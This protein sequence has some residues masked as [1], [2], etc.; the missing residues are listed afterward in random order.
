MSALPPKSP[1]PQ[2]EEEIQDW[3]INRL[4]TWLLLNPDEIDIEQPFA[5]YGLTS[6][7]AV[8]M[9]ADLEDWLGIELSPT[10]AYEYPTIAALSHHLTTEY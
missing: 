2:R 4:S 8:S 1:D 9:T 6:I 10:L 5:G 3:L 7:T